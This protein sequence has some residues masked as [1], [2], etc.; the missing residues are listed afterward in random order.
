MKRQTNTAVS[1]LAGIARLRQTT[2]RRA[3]SWDTTGGNADAWTIASGES[4]VLADIQGPGTITHIW[5]T[6][7]SPDKFYL[8]KVVLSMYWDGEDQPSVLSPVGD[9]FCLGFAKVRRFS[10]LPFSVLCADDYRVNSLVRQAGF[11][12]FLPMPF[13]QAARIELLN[14]TKDPLTLFFHIDYELGTDGLEQTGRF[15]AQWRREHETTPV[16]PPEGS[17]RFGGR[18]LSDKENYLVLE[19]EGHGHFIGC[20]LSVDRSL[21][22]PT[23]EGD[24][25]F[26]IDDDTWPPSLHGTGTEDY[27]GSAWSYPCKE[28][29][30]PYQGG[31]VYGEYELEAS[32]GQLTAYRFH[33]EDPIAFQKRIRF[34]IEHGHANECRADY[35]SVAY[36]YQREPHKPFSELL[37]VEQRL[38]LR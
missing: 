27:F 2:N 19:A 1:T 21:A 33:L 16:P 15:H 12:C 28:F 31:T 36:W 10:C 30:G 35:S 29:Q 18:N 17:E 3:S 7:S 22:E 9:F 6:M 37:P 23:H 26:M 34:S 4:R 8:R 11:N 20:N 25:M 32:V 24:D 14:E 38:P 5:L 13:D